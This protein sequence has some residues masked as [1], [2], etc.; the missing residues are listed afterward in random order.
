MWNQMGLETALYTVILLWLISISLNEASCVKYWPAVAALLITTRPE[1]LF[2]L[3]GLIPAFCVYR[4]KK[5]ALLYSC[6][7]FCVI[8]LLLFLLR[9]FYFH[10]FFQTPFI[11]K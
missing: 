9:F 1:G 4:H 5:K 7:A 3:S 11:I 8:V 2:L 10:E 6:A